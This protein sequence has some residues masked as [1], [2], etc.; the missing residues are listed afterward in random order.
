MSSR[1]MGPN[2]IT[3]TWDHM[4]LQSSHISTFCST[5]IIHTLHHF[6]S[7]FQYSA[8]SILR[9]FEEAAK[10]FLIRSSIETAE[11][12]K[13][14]RI[15]WNGVFKRSFAN[16]TFQNL[17]VR[18]E[19]DVEVTAVLRL[20]PMKTNFSGNI[21]SPLHRKRSPAE[22]WSKCYPCR[23]ISDIRTYWPWDYI[24]G[25]ISFPHED[26]RRKYDALV[27]LQP[28]DI[29]KRKCDTLGDSCP[30]E[31]RRCNYDAARAP[32][33][34]RS[35]WASVGSRCN[36]NQRKLCWSMLSS[37]NSWECRRYRWE[38]CHLSSIMLFR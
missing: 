18:L 8:H 1:T 37:K 12:W 16:N 24:L 15:V 6:T 21:Y 4:G 30:H 26:C 17:T 34:I 25:Y 7:L 13:L 32:W 36:G 11:R 35:H 9:N 20:L 2:D 33:T 14:H 28:H 29:L 19:M 27:A 23:L 10:K 5:S 31:C 22:I 38:I 3:V